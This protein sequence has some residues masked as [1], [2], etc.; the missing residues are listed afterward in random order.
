MADAVLHRCRTPTDRLCPCGRVAREL[1]RRG[2]EAEQRREPWR[3]RDREAVEALTGQ[4]FVPVL[5]LDGEAI[6]DSRR[7]LEHLEW[8]DGEW[9]RANSVDDGGPE[10]R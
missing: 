1:A 6:C 5:V 2:I 8:R 10:R 9:Q 7:I 3:R 4:R